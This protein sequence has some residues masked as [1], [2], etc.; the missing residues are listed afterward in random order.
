MSNFVLK[1]F[2]LVFLGLFLISGAFAF[3]S[4]T[5]FT[6]DNLGQTLT[7]DADINGFSNPVCF[8][9]DDTFT[10]D[11]NYLEID[12]NGHSIDVNT[13]FADL[14]WSNSKNLATLT[15][16]NCDIN[17]YSSSPT[18]FKFS[19]GA[20]DFNNINIFDSNIV[21]SNGAV[22]I[23]LQT[24]S[25]LQVDL[26]FS[27]SNITL[28]GTGGGIVDF[29]V[30]TLNI[31]NLNLTSSSI[32]NVFTLNGDTNVFNLNPNSTITQTAGDFI[33]LNPGVDLNYLNFTDTNLTLSSNV[34]FFNYTG[35]VT[36]KESLLSFDFDNVI[37]D[38][39]LFT[40]LNLNITNDF[41][42]MTNGSDVSVLEFNTSD[43][44]ITTGHLLYT[45][46]IISDSLDMNF[47]DSN[48]YLNGATRSIEFESTD[49]T[50]ISIDSVN[51]NL[52]IG[53]SGWFVLFWDSNIDNFSLTNSTITQ[54]AGA[55]L[56][57][58]TLTSS[59][60]TLDF[61][62]TDLNLTSSDTTIAL[63]KT[64]IG[65]LTV[66][67][68]S[69][70]SPISADFLLLNNNSGATDV[71]TLSI[72]FSGVPVVNSSAE[73]INLNSADSSVTLNFN[74][75]DF[76]FQGTSKA[77][78]IGGDINRVVVN[79]LNIVT[80]NS[81]SA[82]YSITSD[83]NY[84]TSNLVANAIIANT[85]AN[86]FMFA[87]LT[88]NF[89]DINM[90]NSDLNFANDVFWFDNADINNLS[91]HNLDLLDSTNLFTTINDANLYTLYLY[92]SNVRFDT[93]FDVNGIVTAKLWNNYFYDENTSNNN[94]IFESSAS[95]SDVNLD[96]N[97]AS[98][99][100]TNI[101]S[102][103]YKGG[104]YWTYSGDSHCVD[105]TG[106]DYICDANQIILGSDENYYDLLPLT[107]TKTY[108]LQPT[109]ITLNSTVSGTTSTAT[110]SVINNGGAST[111]GSYSVKLY[112]GNV[113]TDTNTSS[114]VVTS[115]STQ[116]YIL[117]WAPAPTTSTT[118]DLNC[119]VT[120]T[121]W[122]SSNNNYTESATITYS[123]GTTGGAGGGSSEE[124]SGI[125]LQ[126]ISLNY[127]GEVLVNKDMTFKFAFKN[128][129]DEDATSSYTA[130]IV[131][132]QKGETIK[133][134]SQTYSEDLESGSQKV[135]SATWKPTKAGYYS[136]E[137]TIEYSGTDDDTGNDTIDDKLLHVVTSL[138]ATTPDANTTS[139]TSNVTA[140]KTIGINKTLQS[141]SDFNSFIKDLNIV[142]QGIPELTLPDV[143]DVNNI[144]L[145]VE[146]T[147]TFK[148]DSNAL[149]CVVTVSLHNVGT[150]TMS[151]YKYIEI[152]PDL[153]GNNR[154]L[155]FDLN[156]INTGLYSI[157]DYTLAASAIDA[158][159][160][161]KFFGLVTNDTSSV[162]LPK[163]KSS[164][165]FDLP[166]KTIGFVV[167]IIIGAGLLAL[168]I[169]YLIK[170]IRSTRS[171]FRYYKTHESRAEEPT[172]KWK[173]LGGDD[174][175]VKFK[176]GKY[177][178][179]E[180][181]HSGPKYKGWK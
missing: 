74:N 111:S 21:V 174:S 102:K 56:Y 5:T 8:Q 92:D 161:A 71:N 162:I 89:L 114:I 137:G 177:K 98:T 168:I 13:D 82:L 20:V 151:G 37:A 60:L 154:Y 70:L 49:I 140:T 6:D 46:G 26:N 59:T 58:D 80:F 105:T 126:A 64:N 180:H 96:F 31:Y 43:I 119:V 25:D 45:N 38:Y 118:Y 112:V 27:G 156:D 121:D 135:Y 76:N 181:K 163:K 94:V 130:S 97:I 17:S 52:N 10:D 138:T 148:C 88:D 75:S 34:T 61:T 128:I 123:A 4:C 16:K 9:L 83:I 12:C 144:Y 173:G 164:W 109:N 131:I 133:T 103:T 68:L 36:T 91:I 145:P 101:V 33:E 141:A 106:M 30:N 78:Q 169:V 15:F 116:T 166:W 149:T 41:L 93:L 48:L 81:T 178:V 107:T 72:S 124:E 160:Q 143:T 55:L 146:V 115:G 85:T 99:L 11:S 108:D 19:T 136:V 28:I 122:N 42:T 120:Y 63:D 53:G 110:C 171:G 73:L 87:N 29:N 7:L 69:V 86:L 157:F 66:S 147:R 14:F 67:N 90:A 1:A 39:L 142:I 165:N 65:S 100:A 51:A 170:L 117:D 57:T 176:G 129:G 134:L 132:T 23:N 24:S 40:D 84:F 150:S 152:L 175:G 139:N 2:F 179:H 159:S 35:V 167:L 125:D 127:T 47:N 18:L 153:N 172:P 77:L 3:T 158:N 113:L 155:T 62:G 50:S 95:A 44:N 104:N 22:L 79:D 54:I 32:G